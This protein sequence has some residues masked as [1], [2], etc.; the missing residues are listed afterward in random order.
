MVYIYIYIYLAQFL[1]SMFVSLS[2]VCAC[3]D[4]VYIDHVCNAVRF[5]IERSKQSVTVYLANRMSYSRL[6]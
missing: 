5:S 2:T 3:V 4:N 1:F 6:T